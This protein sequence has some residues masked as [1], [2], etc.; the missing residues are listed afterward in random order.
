MASYNFPSKLRMA[1][2][3]LVINLGKTLKKCIDYICLHKY[4][5]RWEQ[6][7]SFIQVTFICH[8]IFQCNNTLHLLF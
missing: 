7:T 2:R 3:I 5:N 6:L 8:Y 1:L 4:F